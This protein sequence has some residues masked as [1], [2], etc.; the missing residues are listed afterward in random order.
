MAGRLSARKVQT[1]TSG[2]HSD[3]SGLYL[4]VDK[5][6][7]KRW[8]FIFTFGEKRPEMALGSFPEMSLAEAR[9]AALE[10][11]RLVLRGV[12][13]VEARRA[14]RRPVAT[15]GDVA[16]ELHA[17]RAH[18]WRSEKYRKQW[19]EGL[20]RHAGALWDVDVTAISTDSVLGILRPLWTSKA[21]TAQKTRGQIESVLA[22]ATARGLRSGANVAAWR[23]HLALLLPRP[24]KDTVRPQRA[25]PYQELP[26]IIVKL[27]ER[28]AV[29]IAAFAVEFAIL[30]A[31]RSNEVL[32]MRWQEIDLGARVWTVPATRAK[33]ARPHRVPLCERALGILR[34]MQRAGGGDYVFPGRR[35]GR[36]LRGSSL[37]KALE[38]A[39]A[40]ASVHGTARASF[41]TWGAEKT[42][43]ARELL[44]MSL[45]HSV[46]SATERAYSR[47]DSL[48]R[49]REVMEKWAAFLN[50]ES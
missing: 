35:Q 5:A 22:A 18:G 21:F 11:R 50:G 19:L 49:R 16:R 24:R 12:N 30:T 8:K 47:G 37:W 46:G 13:P 6:G 20:R 2:K 4:M 25:V 34:S 27:R 14:E 48:E 1:A 42:E 41:R 33:S 38:M 7:R 26:A 23:N 45:A 44:E 31:S 17:D 40:D 9:E 10:A 28:Q 43:F 29:A 15:F 36:P 39:G 3:G 32:G